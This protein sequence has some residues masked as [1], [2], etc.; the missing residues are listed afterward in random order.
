MTMLMHCQVF[1]DASCWHAKPQQGTPQ[2]GSISAPLEL[3]CARSAGGSGGLGNVSLPRGICEHAADMVHNATPVFCSSAL[4]GTLLR[5]SSEV[6][7]AL[8]SSHSSTL[9]KVALGLGAR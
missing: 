3:R 9:E 6:V 2:T 4:A 1:F 7:S 8:S 5:H